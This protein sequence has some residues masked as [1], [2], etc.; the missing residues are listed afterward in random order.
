[1]TNEEKQRMLELCAQISI[2]QDH[3][4]MIDLIRE[5]NELIGVKEKRLRP[6]ALFTLFQSSAESA[7]S[8]ARSCRNGTASECRPHGPNGYTACTGTCD[9]CKQA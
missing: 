9:F 6:P 7:F 1:M 2:E 4:R 8:I 3:A 5:L